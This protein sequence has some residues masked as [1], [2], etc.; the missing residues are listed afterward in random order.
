ML[1]AEHLQ[2]DGPVEQR[3]GAGE[4]ARLALERPQPAMMER[5][6]SNKDETTW[7][8]WRTRQQRWADMEDEDEESSEERDV[9]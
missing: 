8:V 6:G 2:R 3:G 7:P 9:E 4:P 5:A 1:A